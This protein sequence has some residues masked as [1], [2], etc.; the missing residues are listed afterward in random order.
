MEEPTAQDDNRLFKGRQIEFMIYD[1]FNISATSDAI[2]D[3]SPI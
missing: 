1:Y 3:F 2:L